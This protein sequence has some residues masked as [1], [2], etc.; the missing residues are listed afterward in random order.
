MNTVK[1][2]A[3]IGPESSG[4]SQLCAE[5]ALH[6]N[7]IWIPE[8][9]REYLFELKSPYSQEDIVN[10]YT[11]QFQMETEQLQNASG[12]IF[13]DTEFL[14][15]SVWIEHSFGLRSE[16]IEQMIRQHPY[17]LYLLTADDLPWEYDILRENPGKGKF[18]FDWYQRLL[19][20]HNFSYA[21]V[22]G[23]GRKRT[24]NAIQHIDKFFS[25]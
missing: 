20:E 19:T 21:I 14:I 12:Y 24:L 13:T 6:Y 9:A 2:I 17:D 18:F 5:L 15:A 1:R 16:L 7:T 3:V 8:Y 4:K 25:S 23:K 22:T 11:T 10:I